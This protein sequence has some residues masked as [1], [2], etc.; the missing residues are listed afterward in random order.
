MK[1]WNFKSFLAGVML[2]ALVM[3]LGVP[4]LASSLVTKEL[5]YNDIQI[6]LNGQTIIPKDA[7]GN[8]VQPFVI[9]GTTYLPIR[10]VASALG[11]NVEWDGKNQTVILGNDPE[12]GVPAKWLG[13][14]ETFTGTGV[15]VK[16]QKDGQYDSY[17]TANNGQTFDRYYYPKE[18][19]GTTYLLKGQ[20]TRFTGTLYIPEYMKST[21]A[22]SRFLV[23]LDDELA[24]TSKQVGVG[25]EPIDFSVDVS[26]AYKME[27]VTQQVRKIND[28]TEEPINGNYHPSR[29]YDDN[30]LRADSY[31]YNALI[32]NAALWTD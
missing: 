31:W 16:I 7:S 21:A 5:Y 25:I 10:A 29:T 15:E 18:G 28:G 9:N 23:Y 32:G 2:M 14:M 6:R 4:A 8:V 17:T 19:T 26:G 20:Y 13:E 30:G 11:L 24:Y 1:K 27:I 3:G 12:K 22:N